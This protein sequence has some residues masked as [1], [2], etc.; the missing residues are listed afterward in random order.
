MALALVAYPELDARDAEWITG[1]REVHDPLSRDIIA[2]HIT[3]VFQVYNVGLAE[4]SAHV[5]SV[6][7]ATP[8]IKFILRSAVLSGPDD[9]HH[10][11]HVFLVPDEGYS[12]IIRLHDRLY[13]GLLA[14]ELRLDI[15]YVPHVGVGNNVDPKV[16]K[17]LA[18]TLNAHDFEIIGRIEWLDIL[19][20]EN[21]RF[22]TL[23]RVRLQP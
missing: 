9:E 20:A 3:L 6:A 22:D 18:D 4:F 21:M 5:N 1:I 11:T 8:P 19:H 16:C 13:S 17:Q 15:P 2:A 7:Q 14:P 10:C 23:E 12:R